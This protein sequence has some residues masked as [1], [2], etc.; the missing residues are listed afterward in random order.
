MKIADLLLSQILP[1]LK[2][3]QPMGSCYLCFLS[4]FHENDLAHF[5]FCRSMPLQENFLHLTCWNDQRM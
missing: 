2:F 3:H 5:N 1:E 4:T